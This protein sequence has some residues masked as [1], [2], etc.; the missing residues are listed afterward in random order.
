[1]RNHRGELAECAQSNL[2]FVQ[3]GAVL[4]PPLEAGLLPGITREFV[5]EIGGRARASRCAKQVL[6]DEDLSRRGRGVPHQ[7]DAR[8]RRRSS[9]VDDR[10][11][12][13]GTPG[14]VTQALLRAFRRD[15]AAV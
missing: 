10:T 1:M 2:F 14:P 12:G 9:R 4:T 13:S 6:R 8:D 7:H 11:I 5:F 15:G 3:D